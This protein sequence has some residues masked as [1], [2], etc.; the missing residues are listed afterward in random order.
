MIYCSSLLLWINFMIRVL[1]SRPNIFFQI[2]WKYIIKNAILWKK[3]DV[4]IHFDR[5]RLVWPNEHWF[6]YTAIEVFEWKLYKKLIWC[7][8][9]LDLWWYLWESAVR[10]AQYNKQVTVVEAN[11]ANYIYIAKNIK[12][13]NN[14]ISFHGA[15]VYQQ[16]QQLYYSWND[17]SA[18]GKIVTTPTDRKIKNIAIEKIF[19]SDID[20]LKMD[21]EWWEYDIISYFMKEKIL[22]LQKW[23][24][25]FHDIRQNKNIIQDFITLLVKNHYTLQYENIYWKDLTK[26]KFFIENIAVIYFE[27]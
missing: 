25:E 16:D 9:I 4:S 27:G 1:Y 21:I 15:I 20:G 13:Y 26:N 23:Y 14:I 11:D 19:S 10:F 2:I 5:I 3:Q 24:I 8:H 7:N 18:G 6:F 12:P 22:Q 17:Y